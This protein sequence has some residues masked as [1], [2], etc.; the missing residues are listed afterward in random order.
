MR[1]IVT[2]CFLASGALSLV[3]QVLWVRHLAMI[4]GH[5]VL[6]VSTVVATFMAGLGLGAWVAGRVAHRVRRP[7]FGY[8]L[9]EAAIGLLALSTPTLMRLVEG[10]FSALAQSGG[11]IAVLLCSALVLL[12]PTVAMGAT[13]PL[14]TRWYART[15]DA[16]GRDLG[17][18][19]AIN[20]TGA[21]AGAALS[22]FVLLPSFGQPATLAGAAL[23]NVIVGA[24]AMW[25]GRD[26]MPEASPPQERAQPAVSRAV[27]VAFFLSG[28]AAMIEQVGWTRAFELFTGSTTYAFSLIVCTFIGGLA[29]GGHLARPQ[30][31]RR[32]DRVLGL[33][34]LNIAIACAAAV[35]IPLLGELPLLL[36][37]PIAAASSSFV[38]TQLLLFGVLSALVLLPTALMGATWPFAVRALC[39]DAASAAAVVGRANA[40]NTTG[41]IVGSLSGGLLLIPALGLRRALWV[42]V[43]IN[44]VAA[45]VLL[46]RRDRR[47]VL[48]PALG[49]LGLFISAEWNPRH[50][51]LAPHLYAKDLIA[52][53]LLRQNTAE[54]GSL[55]FHK[56]GLGA[57]VSVLQRP[58]GGI[59][60][61]INGKTDASTDQDTL[62]Q[63]LVGHLPLLLAPKA[64]DVLLIGLGSGMS[65][66]SVLDH[67]VR[68][69]EVVELLPE[70]LEAARV[71]GPE[72]GAPLD[73]PR[74]TVR[75]AD[76]RQVL[77][78]GGGRY[79][80]V[81]SQ[82]TN[83]FIS[84]VG[85]LFT[86]E[87][88]EGMRRALNADG[89]ALAWVQG[90]LLPEED[91]RTVLRTFLTVFPEATLWSMGMYDF[92]LVGTSGGLA[93]PAAITE[94]ITATAERR[95]GKW[96]GLR[97]LSDLQR[98]HLLSAAS[99][100]TYAGDGVIHGDADPFLEFS[101]PMGLYDGVKRLDVA[102]LLAT[103]EHWTHL[104][105]A[106]RA[107]TLVKAMAA[108]EQ[109]ALHG[110]PKQLHDALAVDPNNPFFRDRQ[111]RILHARAVKEAIA[112][113]MDAAYR[114]GE[115]ALTL[116]PSSLTT[117]RLLAE[118]A[119]QQQ[120][121]PLAIELLTEA[122][123]RLPNNPYSWLALAETARRA[124][125]GAQAARAMAEV[126]RLDPDL[127]ELR[128]P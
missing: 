25:A 88:F 14:L 103:R 127:P 59:S 77:L 51:N 89:L 84:G 119:L 101:A 46:V 2:A 17:W 113:R 104:P 3:Y 15:D 68:S 39:G 96:T 99:A 34:A 49:L 73:D 10:A 87:A 114:L 74:V 110:D 42:A 75:V 98:H 20:T 108:G 102:A 37:E 65:L 31:D 109:G 4:V 43:T 125:D 58:Q 26:A 36:I 6:A 117:R 86:R 115:S 72:I 90:Y 53:P 71:F 61:R 106:E 120:Q 63:G 24:L 80:V 93:D 19:Y 28:A 52:D 128:A 8:G 16:I 112:G 97:D 92:V 78:H 79:D 126:Q 60:L 50:M 66:A 122:C 30:A 27:L 33:A 70:V 11:S 45:A 23:A 5:S 69:V 62:T 83:L 9:L 38:R 35:L 7:L 13:L 111:A 48:L 47:L 91:F 56:E 18:L 40:W 105:D 32:D 12:P 116:E 107:A 94:R 54:S 82:P 44:L 100:R 124:G 22:G 41:A 57:T 121:G 81:I 67:P 1:W 64:E 123:R 21:M 76:G 118:I 85:T 55:L 95:S 29:L